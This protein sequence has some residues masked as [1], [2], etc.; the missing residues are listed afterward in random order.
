MR[1]MAKDQA[2]K[3]PEKKFLPE[4]KFAA[5]VTPIIFGV[6]ALIIGQAV[7]QA[8]QTM[9]IQAAFD[10]WTS[11]DGS[12]QIL[13]GAILSVVGLIALLIGVARVCARIDFLY[14]K[15]GGVA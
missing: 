2:P 12:S 7:Y 13:V 8:G 4:P 6:I 10:R 15:A 9:A 1:P 5:S 14:R 11:D 3:L